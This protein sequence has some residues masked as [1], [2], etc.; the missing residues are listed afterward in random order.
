M[1][2][3]KEKQKENG[4]WSEKLEAMKQF[5]DKA[6]DKVKAQQD[7][8]YGNLKGFQEALKNPQHLADGGMVEDQPVPTNAEMDQWVVGGAPQ[9]SSI[10]PDIKAYVNKIQ[11]PSP[12]DSI[13]GN[14]KDNMA[15]L[16]TLRK[17]SLG[18]SIGA[19][20]AGLGDSIARAAGD[21]EANHLGAVTDQRNQ[22][23]E[24]AAKAQQL[25]AQQG[26][27]HLELGEH[28]DAKDPN[29]ELSKQAQQTYGPLLSKTIPGI[30][31]SKMPASLI[32]DLTGKSVDTM[33]AESEARMA[34]ATLGLKGVEANIAGQ[35]AA[36][37]A[38]HQAAEDTN[39]ADERRIGAAK[40]LN[41]MTGITHPINTLMS[42]IPG[43]NANLTKNTL[44][45]I[46]Q[47]HPHDD[48]AVAW[49]KANPNDPRSAKILQLNKE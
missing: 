37:E 19:A 44:Q 12:V 6:H 47:P 30:D 2:K 17:P 41:N 21:K 28:L 48:A 45:N 11:P 42:L 49:A 16:N 5:A 1:D 23:F 31:V 43:T 3:P 22:Q 46:I 39:M 20:F 29:S 7:E 14:Q 9:A 38:K 15:Q 32:A 8:G 18:S 10:P 33:K 24:N 35:K 4:F 34:A 27:E 26:K 36:Q 25:N 13:L 40:E